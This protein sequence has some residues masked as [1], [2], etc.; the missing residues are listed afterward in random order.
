MSSTNVTLQKFLNSGYT[1]L[2]NEPLSGGSALPAHDLTSKIIVTAIPNDASADLGYIGITGAGT[3][4]A[5][6]L[7][8]QTVYVDGNAAVRPLFQ[9]IVL[10][11]ETTTPED[12]SLFATGSVDFRVMYLKLNQ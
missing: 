7:Y 5:F 6:P 8:I 11:I 12:F 10:E 4:G 3:A 1:V 9:P 2:A